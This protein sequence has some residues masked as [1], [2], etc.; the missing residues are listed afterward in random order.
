ML[1]LSR[2]LFGM[3]LALSDFPVLK[4]VRG[5]GISDSDIYANR[6]APLFSYT[7]TFYHREPYF[8]LMHPDESEFGRY[9]FVICSDVL[10]HI[11]PPV[12]AAF[13]T[14]AKLLKPSGVLILTLPYSLEPAT[15]E[16]F[17]GLKEFGILD[18]GGRSVLVNRVGDGYEVHDRLVFHNGPGHTLE[19]RV[20]TEAEIRAKLIVAGLTEVLIQ[21]PVSAEFGVCETGP[22]S[23]PI[24][25]RRQAFALSA[26]GVNELVSQWAEQKRLVETVGESRWVQLGRRLSVGP[27]VRRK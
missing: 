23:L 3:D 18:L 12:D 20:F 13:D 4:S 10:E 14:L 24:V 5:L 2:A 17:P 16:H 11:P 8:D 7:N 9:D 27:D 21:S 25:A 26:S 1:V 6:L 15:I 22:C 19:M